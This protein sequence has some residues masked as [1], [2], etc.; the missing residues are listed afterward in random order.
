MTGNKRTSAPK[1]TNH[2]GLFVVGR[3][4][5]S[6]LKSH[7]ASEAYSRLLVRD[8]CWTTAGTFI[9]GIVCLLLK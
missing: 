9:V 8:I 5:T 3:N 2:A 4:H 1:P 7:R 6:A